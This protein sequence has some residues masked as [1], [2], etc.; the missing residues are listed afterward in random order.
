MTKF[1]S[2]AFVI[3]C[4][5]PVTLKKGVARLIK[6]LAICVSILIWCFWSYAV[7]SWK[8]FRAIFSF[9][10]SYNSSFLFIFWSLLAPS[11]NVRKVKCMLK[12]IQCQVRSIDFSFE[13]LQAILPCIHVHVFHTET[14]NWFS[15]QFSRL[16]SLGMFS[17]VKDP[18]VNRYYFIKRGLSFCGT[19]WIS[20][21]ICLQNHTMV[22]CSAM[23]ELSYVS[24]SHTL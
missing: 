3:W 1:D 12:S 8:V 9:I 16:M 11:S 24:N 10:S 6:A 19:W 2:A 23:C 14:Y 5:V 18:P 7:N 22:E 15:F 20:L 13:V 17:N 21:Q 4:C